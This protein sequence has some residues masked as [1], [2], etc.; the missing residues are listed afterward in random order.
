MLCTLFWLGHKWTLWLHN[1][2][3]L[4]FKGCQR[5]GQVRWRYES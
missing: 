5:C 3:G 4:R 2:N 1:I